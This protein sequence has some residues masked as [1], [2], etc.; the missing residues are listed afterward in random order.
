MTGVGVVR[1]LNRARSSRPDPGGAVGSTGIDKRPVEGRVTVG[2]LGLE[3]DVVVDTANHGGPDKA[4]YA[5]A[6]ED[7]DWWVEELGREVT[8]GAFGENLTL[9]GVDVT[10]AVVGERWAVGDTVVVEV[11]MPRIPCTTFQRW[12]DEPQWVRRFTDHGAPGAYLSVLTPGEV[13]AGD[14][15]RVV[16]RPAHG[17]TVGDSFLRSTPERMRRLLDAAAA[18]EV[19]L[20]PAMR[21]HAERVAARD[22]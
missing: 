5:Y 11:R 20:A 16:H 21:E 18:G 8:P 13:E 19:D 3:G 4:V 9:S 7:Q 17:V 2:P 15:V 1:S 6:V 12:M 22:R 10:G 14:A